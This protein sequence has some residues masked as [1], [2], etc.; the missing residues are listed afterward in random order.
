MKFDKG[1]L[2]DKPLHLSSAV[3]PG[4]CAVC[5]AQFT[6]AAPNQ[7]TCSRKCKLIRDRELRYRLLDRLEAERGW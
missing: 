2:K 6:P 7:R 1:W 5:G 4:P 3:D